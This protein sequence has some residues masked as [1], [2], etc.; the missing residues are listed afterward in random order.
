MLLGNRRAI[1][2]ASRASRWLGFAGRQPVSTAELPLE[3]VKYNSWRISSQ[4]SYSSIRSNTYDQVLATSALQ[5]FKQTLN[6]PPA[7]CTL[8]EI[9]RDVS[10][11]TN[12]EITVHGYI[13]SRRDASKKLTFAE[14]HNTSLSTLIQLVS[15]PTEGADGSTSPHQILRSIEEHTPVA[16]SGT[17]KSRKVAS[18]RQGTGQEIIAAVE[19]KVENV[20][21]LNKFPQDIIMTKETQFP[22]EQR[23][24]QLRNS[25]EIRHAL[26]FRSKAA[27]LVRSEL[28][29]GHGFVE[30][31]TPLLFKSTPE[32]AR[33]F[34]VPTRTPGQ[35]YA[36]P[37]SPQ[38]YKQILMA[39]GVPRYMQIAKC[40]RDEDLRA[41]RQPEFTQV[42]LE[43]GFATGE[44]VRQTVEALLRRL[45]GTLLGVTDL[46]TPFPRM[47]YEQAMS[48]YGSDKPDLRLGSKIQ[49][50]DY[51]LPVDLV[52]KISDLTL[53]AVDVMKISFNG[54]PNE[55]RKFV[56]SFM[57]SPES[58]P[59]MQNP[60]GQPGIFIFDSRK[61]LQGL[62]PFGFE[63]AEQLEDSLELQDGDLVVLQAR[64]AVPFSGGSTT[65]GNLR[66]SLHK[67]AVAAKL[68]PPPTGF[69]F[70]W[71]TD[72]PLFSPSS[73]SEP[74]QGG[75][76]GISATHHPFTSPKTAEDVD[77]LL[78][79][80]LEVKADHY[81]IVVNGVE[82]GGGSR[83]IHD[84]AVQ[85]LIMREVL[86]MSDAR[87][88]DFAH[89][90]EVLRSGCP[91]HAGIAL[92]FDRLIAVMLG[93]ESVRDVIAFPKSGGGEDKLVESPSQMT[94]SQLETYHLRLRS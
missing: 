58:Q 9:A 68:L 44:D 88:Q 25:P 77:L 18:S 36:L 85:E 56:S 60:D 52:Q 51:M 71:I 1:A 87:M 19:L 7:T 35:A 55:T 2:A 45:W 15:T 91:P 49:R 17:V 24:L 11:W 46:P 38:Q 81:D 94:E 10:T 53:P 40:F 42:D 66:L 78:T 8:D 29:D 31:E 57:D 41:D 67:A 34:L 23:H 84:S 76:A 33:E 6:S 28:C 80:P 47:T 21:P 65:L 20:V 30:I 39:S 63:A 59:F 72:F 43:M 83:R 69:E 5:S 12:R 26:T 75:S 89:L 62:M 61:P 82:L 90:L 13:G 86:K 48:T 22:P 93:K 37:Q 27:R 32:G 54:D 16:V 3:V 50:V 4:Q 74:G 92:G 14:L 70:T 79:D 73:D 64:E